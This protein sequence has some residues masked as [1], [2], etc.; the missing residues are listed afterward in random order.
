MKICLDTNAYTEFKKGS[1]ALTNLIE[2]ADEIFIPIAVLGELF[3]G[4]YLGSKTQHNVA[5]L[6]EFLDLPGITI[7]E[8]NRDIA[9]R[10]G[11]LV[12]DLSKKG[13]PIPTN[14]VW[15]AASAFETGSH[16]VSYD[17]HFEKIPGLV[18]L[19]P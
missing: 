15:I 8:A 4:F 19:S 12:K 13:I 6:N 2:T 5:E 9:H 1:S 18:I 7:V 17:R 11:L 14:D 3:A 10:Y 16:L